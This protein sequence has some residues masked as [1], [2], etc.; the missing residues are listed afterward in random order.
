MARSYKAGDIGWASL[1][2]FYKTGTRDEKAVPG[3]VL[4][5]QIFGDLIG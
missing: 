4:A 3:A 2:T 5:I 1:K